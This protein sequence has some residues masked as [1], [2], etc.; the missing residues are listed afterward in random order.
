MTMTPK[1]LSNLRVIVGNE[2]Q[3]C[4]EHAKKAWFPHVTSAIIVKFEKDNAEGVLSDLYRTQFP[5]SPNLGNPERLVLIL[6]NVP[7]VAELLESVDGIKCTPNVLCHFTQ[8]N[9]FFN[10]LPNFVKK[11]TVCHNKGPTS[12]EVRMFKI[13]NKEQKKS[14]KIALNPGKTGVHVLVGGTRNPSENYIRSE[15]VHPGFDEGHGR[16]HELK[17]VKKLRRG[18]AIV[19]V[20]AGNGHFLKSYLVFN[21]NVCPD[22]LVPGCLHIF[23]DMVA[24]AVDEL[25]RRVSTNAAFKNSLFVCTSSQKPTNKT[26]QVHEFNGDQYVPVPTAVVLEAPREQPIVV[27]SLEVTSGI[28]QKDA[29]TLG[30]IKERPIVA[31][32]QTELAFFEPSRLPGQRLV[33]QIGFPADFQYS[34]F[35]DG[36][37]VCNSVLEK[38][39]QV[40]VLPEQPDIYPP[41]RVTIDMVNPTDDYYLR[42]PKTEQFYFQEYT[43]MSP[44]GVFTLRPRLRYQVMITDSTLTLKMQTE[45][46]PFHISLD[47][48][49]WI[50]SKCDNNDGKGPRIRFVEIK[51]SLGSVITA[52]SLGKP[53]VESSKRRAALLFD[54][55][56]V[57][58]NRFLPKK[59]KMTEVYLERN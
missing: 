51:Q 23:F 27:N 45:S 54:Q 21:P 24:D 16:A 59:I 40:F 2:H 47:D 7:T 34:L 52:A 32:L 8:I 39:N 10:P 30:L 43:I 49:T 56:D 36:K 28:D 44:S 1:N 25:A 29:A 14:G 4:T 3:A 11:Y 53:V 13:A 57:I 50:E 9:D 22:M 41:C 31:T 6:I 17:S 18:D 37:H 38:G 33:L 35:F 48:A 19:F 20:E 58:Q 15:F 46:A 5:S 55:C 42:S 26:V 12:A